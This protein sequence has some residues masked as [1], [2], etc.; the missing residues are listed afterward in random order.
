MLGKQ[1]ILIFLVTSNIHIINI[2]ALV[3]SNFNMASKMAAKNM[4]LNK[5]AVKSNLKQL[6]RKTIVN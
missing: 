5:N 1:G 2:M 4:I 6:F 3:C